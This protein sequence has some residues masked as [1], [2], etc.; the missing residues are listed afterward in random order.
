MFILAGVYRHRRLVSPKGEHTRPTASR[1]RA[2]LFNICQGYIEGARFLDL[3]AGS[4]AMG[5]EALSHG[6]SS[7]VFVDNHKEAVRCIERN[8]ESLEVQ[9]QAIVLQGQVLHMIDLL[10]RQKRQFDI[11][12]AD[13]PYHL[14]HLIDTPISEKVIR[15]IDESTLLAPDGTLFIE[16]AF[17]FQPQLTDLKTLKLKNTR[18]MGMAALQQ[19]VFD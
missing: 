3:F 8:I 19:Y 6:A 5:L 12:F 16:E 13:P 2:A 15:R 14:S 7:V 10:E 9:S 11:I 17:E 1:L 18:R 4:G